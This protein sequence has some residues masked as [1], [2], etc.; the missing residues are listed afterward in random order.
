[1]WLFYAR[2]L[3]AFFTTQ[4]PSTARIW[5]IV[6]LRTVHLREISPSR[7]AALKKRVLS[8]PDCSW[9]LDSQRLQNV[10]F[11]IPMPQWIDR[12]SHHAA[13]IFLVGRDQS[14]DS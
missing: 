3:L 13:K 1:M 12:I 7:I 8:M 11:A 10:G 14:A 6:G 4:D 5:S 9:N 2:I